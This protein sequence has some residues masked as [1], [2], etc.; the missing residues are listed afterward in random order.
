MTKAIAKSG[1]AAAPKPIVRDVSRDLARVKKLVKALKLDG[2]EEGLSY[3][4]PCLKV[5][6]KFLTR[7]REPGVLVLMCSREEKELLMEVNPDVYFETDHYKGWPAVL[8]HTP[9]ISD[10][11]L[12][13][14]LQVAWRMQAP[15]KLLNATQDPSGGKKVQ[16]RPAT[17]RR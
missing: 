15:K 4:L 5:V 6:G 2:I 16:R 17:K 1:K 3:G 8:I 13:H 12:K 7:V 9:K 11:E 10:T 14:R